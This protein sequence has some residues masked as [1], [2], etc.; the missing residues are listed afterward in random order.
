MGIMTA[1]TEEWRDANPIAYYLSKLPYRAA[2]EYMRKSLSALRGGV[3][4]ERP[5]TTTSSIEK[6]LCGGESGLSAVQ[7]ARHTGDY[8]W[9]STPV[10]QSPHVQFLSEYAQKGDRIFAPDTFSNTS[11]SRFAASCIAALGSYLDCSREDQIEDLARRFVALFR[12]KLSPNDPGH[13]TFFREPGSTIYVHPIQ[14]SDCY[15][16]R[17][18]LHQL[19]IAYARG[20]REHKIYVMPPAGVTLVQQWILDHS[21]RRG[22]VREFYQ[23]I[24]C[25]ELGDEWTLIRKCSDRF[26]MMNG[27]LASQGLLPPVC[28]TYLDIA[29][30]YGWFVKRFEELGFDS[31]GGGEVDWAACEIGKHVYGLREG[32]VT[33][34]EVVRFLRSLAQ[35]FDIVSCL[36][37]L[38]HF[39]IGLP[40]RASISPEEMLRLVDEHTGKVLFFDMGEEHEQWFR[41]SLRG[42]SPDHIEQWL[43]DNTSFKSF[44]R[45]GT[46]DDA[47]AT[48]GA[49]YGRTL[50]ACMR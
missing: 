21:F 11:Y 40:Y 32:Q 9:P 19:A 43:R 1:A 48:G 35:P 36:S 8:L 45:L 7:F 27:F 20:E 41:E 50:F 12:G 14:Y 10:T 47:A 42:W 6:L 39:I 23:P 30:S 34:S 38:H 26:E 5:Y 44:Y 29:C 49:N 4:S 18:G 24:E 25:P 22:D 31:S 33:R 15:E 3:N 28:R 16:V 2:T 46:D 13:S 17:D 37:I